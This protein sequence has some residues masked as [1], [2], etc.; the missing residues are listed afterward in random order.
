MPPHCI[1]PTSIFYKNAP[2]T[3]ATPTKKPPAPTPPFTAAPECVALAL[4]A[5]AE[6]E[7]LFTEA[8]VVVELIIVDEPLMLVVEDMEL[9]ADAALQFESFVCSTPNLPLSFGQLL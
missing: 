5:V 1:P 6:L 9:Y 8:L 4:A 3:A 7:E 2:I